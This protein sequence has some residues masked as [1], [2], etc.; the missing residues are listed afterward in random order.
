MPCFDD[1]LIYTEE[2]YLAPT[3]RVGAS[4]TLPQSLSVVPTQ[5]VGTRTNKNFSAARARIRLYKETPIAMKRKKPQRS[6][7]VAIA[8]VPADRYSVLPKCLDAIYRNT[9]TPFRVI[10]VDGNAGPSTRAYLEKAQAE[11]RN[12][13]VVRV[14]RILG[15]AEARNL[16]LQQVKERYVAIVEND[17]I[18]CD[19]WL[20]PL[21]SCAQEER[22]AVVGPLIIDA[23]YNRIHAAGCLIEETRSK[24]GIEFRDKILEVEVVPGSVA[25][26]RMRIDYPERHCLLIDRKFLPDKE[27]FDELEPFDADLG[28][29]LRKRK[30]S[31]FFEPASVV[32]FRQTPPIELIDLEYFIRRWDINRWEV[33]RQRFM[34]NWKVQFDSTEK[35]KFYR[36][37][38][39]NLLLA[40]WFPNRFTLGMANLYTRSKRLLRS[41]ALDLLG[42]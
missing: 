24:N 28:Y 42:R 23:L 1:L 30:F 21:L 25:L 3:L 36:S 6:T 22:A 10:V 29:L 4:Q 14:D 8:L 17:L 11:K 9:K 35:R 32:E 33:E 41:K 5:S 18:V 16:A 40:R 20:E 34:Q 37:Q 38:H 26:S 2:I 19:N 15:S 27:L 12:L 31:A 13:S 7:P 39:R